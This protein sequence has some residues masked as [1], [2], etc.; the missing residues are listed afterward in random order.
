MNQ[1]LRETLNMGQGEQR[2]RFIN[3][4]SE[5]EKAEFAKALL[6]LYKEADYKKADLLRA[7]PEAKGYI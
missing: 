2:A 3:E 1:Y 4:M 5:A 7:I 6:K